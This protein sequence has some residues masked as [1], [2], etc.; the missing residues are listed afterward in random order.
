[1]LICRGF[2]PS[3]WRGC[4]GV[5]PSKKQPG[6]ES[7]QF[8]PHR[9]NLDDMVELYLRASFLLRCFRCLLCQSLCVL[10]RGVRKLALLKVLL[11]ASLA[12]LLA[13]QSL[14]C[15]HPAT[16]PTTCQLPAE[17]QNASPRFVPL[18]LLTPDLR[19]IEREVIVGHE[20]DRAYV[21]PLH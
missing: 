4:L 3:W 8:Q 7:G 21:R 9:T 11:S 16:P 14:A 12:A 15:M 20:W 13:Q 2:C 1:M 17:R 6:R 18:P 5:W 19:I 10:H